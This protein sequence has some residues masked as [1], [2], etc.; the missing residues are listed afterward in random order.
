MRLIIGFLLAPKYLNY[1]HHFFVMLTVQYVSLK[2]RK[3][4]LFHRYW[5]LPT[6]IVVNKICTDSKCSQ[7]GVRTTN[8][9]V[10]NYPSSN[11]QCERRNFTNDEWTYWRECH[12]RAIAQNPCALKN[13]RGKVRFCLLS[14]RIHFRTQKQK[15]HSKNWKRC[16]IAWK[17][18]WKRRTK[19]GK[20]KIFQWLI[21][22]NSLANLLSP[23]AL[24]MATSTSQLRFEV[25]WPA[26]NDIWRKRAILPA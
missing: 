20:L 12:A 4:S 7:S 16:K 14:W 21:W 6:K 18:F 10:E 1:M 17:I 13:G 11:Q 8:F 22:I 19:T 3:A 2:F 25:L 15:Y 5:D 9:T 24:K 23:Y 26:S